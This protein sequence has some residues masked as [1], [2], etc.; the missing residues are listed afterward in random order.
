MRSGVG[1]RL[2]RSYNMLADFLNPS[3]YD[4]GQQLQDLLTALNSG[5]G[6]AE[7]LLCLAIG[8]LL[9]HAFSTRFKP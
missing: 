7:W 6:Q 9:F 5:L 3:N 2:G 4:N 8:V 1:V